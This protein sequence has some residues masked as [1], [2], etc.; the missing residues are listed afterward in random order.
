MSGRQFNKS[1]QQKSVIVE[2]AVDDKINQEEIDNAVPIL[3]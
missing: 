1:A 3:Q 2:E